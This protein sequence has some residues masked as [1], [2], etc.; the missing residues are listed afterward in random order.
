MC[1]YGR[2]EWYWSLMFLKSKLK[3]NHQNKKVFLILH[4]V[5][6]L[7]PIYYCYQ[8]QTYYFCTCTYIYW[9]RIMAVEYLFRGDTLYNL[10]VQTDSIG[11]SRAAWFCCYWHINL[12][13]VSVPEPLGDAENM[14]Q[15]ASL[16]SN[17]N[18]IWV[19][20]FKFYF[21]TMCRCQLCPSEL[22][23]SYFCELFNRWLLRAKDILYRMNWVLMT[24]L[25]HHPIMKSERL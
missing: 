19:R 9:V 16:F 3:Q 7:E 6:P 5:L 21:I 8:G 13:S 17:H 22:T 23:E 4:W 20:K 14:K 10:L 15:I 2:L 12:P 24:K 11:P 1:I 18:W 25:D